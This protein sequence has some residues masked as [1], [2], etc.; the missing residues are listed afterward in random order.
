M[1]TQFIKDETGKAP[2]VVLPIREFER[3]SALDDEQS[4]KDIPYQ[5]D[6]HDNTRVPDDVVDIMFEQ[7]VSLLAAWHIYRG[8]SQYDVAEKAGITQS[9]ISQAE[10]K[11]A[12]PQAK[13]C[14]RLA[15]VYD[16][17]P[18]QLIL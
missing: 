3:L 14:E 4:F 6:E 10:K 12:K 11:G 9:A 16:C 8:L 18:E 5:A 13:T 15:K 1:N 7:D 17:L 2:F